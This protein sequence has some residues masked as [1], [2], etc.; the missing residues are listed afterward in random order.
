MFE[1]IDEVAILEANGVEW[2]PSGIYGYMRDE[3]HGEVR[4]SQ[5][6]QRSSKPESQAGK[7]LEALSLT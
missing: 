7:L 1:L 3:L 6:D 4:R 2:L 5:G